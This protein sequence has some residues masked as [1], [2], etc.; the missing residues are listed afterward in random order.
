MVQ[1]SF[2]RIT[3]ALDI[4]K[5]IDNGPLKGFHELSIIKHQINLHDTITI[6]PAD[7][8]QIECD[9][10][11]VPC[12]NRNICWK[13]AE[14]LSSECG[15]DK[16]VKI[17]IQKNIPVMGGLAGG[18]A[19]AATV[20]KMLNE[21]GNL[22]LSCERL[23]MLGQKLGMDVP[24]YFVGKTAFD[25]EATSVLYP[26]PNTLHLVFILAIP[27]FGVSTAEAYR[28]LDYSCIGNNRNLTNKM[29]EHLKADNRAGV[30]EMMH[31]DFE[32]VL[33]KK[34]PA[35]ENIKNRLLCLGC[36]QAIVSGSGSTVIGVANDIDSAQ[37][38]CAGMNCKTVI[39][40]SLN[41]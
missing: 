7:S 25:S 28:E 14:L 27:D 41:T 37:K 2:T 9:N 16:N 29:V 12:D 19:N 18:S 8:L 5:K 11:L 4:I 6:T 26:I 35:L 1:K 3:L 39:A 40:E 15:L 24:F 33:F 38:I 17:S 20:L 21:M 23:A 13:A 22:G 32:H 10:P 30:L 36:E 34:Y 31:N